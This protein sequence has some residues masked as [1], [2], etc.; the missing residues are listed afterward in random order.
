MAKQEAKKQQKRKKD[1]VENEAEIENGR[2]EEHVVEKKSKKVKTETTGQKKEKEQKNE[3]EPKT[4]KQKKEKD[5]VKEVSQEETVKTPKK[6]MNAKKTEESKEG[7][8]KQKEIKASSS[9]S[10]A[11]QPE[12]KKAS[13]DPTAQKK[14][15]KK[16]EK[17]EGKKEE[18]KEGSKKE[19]K[20]EEKKEGT[21][22]EEKKEE[23][24]KEGT[25]EEKKEGKKEEKEKQ[26]PDATQRTVHIKSLPF[27][28]TDDQLTEVFSTFGEVEESHTV[29]D[30]NTG[31][32][33]GYGFVVFQKAASA[34]EAIKT[35]TLEINRKRCTLHH[36]S[37]GEARKA[38]QQPLQKKG[39]TGPQKEGGQAEKN[40]TRLVCVRNLPFESD[41]YGIK[42]IFQ[43]CG[44]IVKVDVVTDFKTKKGKGIAYLTF[45]E[46]E[47]VTAA[48][49][50]NGD[51]SMGR[52]ISVTRANK[53]KKNKG[54]K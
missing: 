1:D 41:I 6:E 24:K 4:K 31:R 18:K 39:A 43:K 53:K 47:G 17:K 11:T 7:Q 10:D 48:I 26:A 19:E 50:M 27:S 49:K 9:E 29:K 12:K 33:L 2:A 46:V 38:Q 14:E 23:K 21:K 15:G 13:T 25:K 30:K 35:S 42:Q 45:K 34:T 32:P 54:K 36:A 3:E 8:K 16:E 5:E 44:E 22:K 37:E 40:Q 52:P 51:K 28:V 20:K